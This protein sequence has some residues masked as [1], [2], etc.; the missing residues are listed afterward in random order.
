MCDPLD[1]AKDAFSDAV[2]KTLEKPA[3][4]L[5]GPITKEVGIALGDIGSVFGFYVRDNLKKVFGR[6]AEQRNGKPIQPEEFQ[7]VLP[8]LQ[9]A[10]LQSDDELQEKWAALLQ[11]TAT[12]PGMVLP[13]FGHTLSQLTPI[14]ARF[15]DDL[16]RLVMTPSPSRPHP[17]GNESLNYFDMMSIFDPDLQRNL[18][19]EYDRK[20]KHISL[21]KEQ[22]AAIPKREMF[23][24]MIHD[25]ERLGILGTSTDLK[26]G[27]ERAYKI[28]GRILEIPGETT[29]E[30]DT[31]LTPYGISFIKAVMPKK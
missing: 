2:S 8:L 12:D 7:R 9:G 19:T 29:L 25:F 21:S 23:D 14:E 6:W 30:E 15:L 3:E 27:Q 5:L 31:F 4:N 20:Y 16:W 17:T 26:T 1:A 28:D 13:S 18:T 10:S 22:L 24:L 11:S